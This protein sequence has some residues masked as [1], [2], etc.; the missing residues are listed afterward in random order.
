MSETNHTPLLEVRDV[1][2]TFVVRP[3]LGRSK[4]VHALKDISFTIEAGKA[5]ALVGESGSGKSTCGRAIARMF[6]IDDG[7]I[8]FKGKDVAAARN[9]AERRANA[10]HIQMVFQD[11]F[12]SLNPTHTIRHHLLR[13]LR[14]HKRVAAGQTEDEAL[15]QV[16][17]DVELDVDNTLDKYP[18]QLSGGQRQRVNLAR[19]L[20]VGAELIIADEPTSML[21]VS[22]RRSVLQLMKRLKEERGIA[23]LYITHD[24]ATA[25][26]LAEDTAA[27]FAGRIVEFGPSEEVV[28]APLHPYTK[29]L[30]SSVSDPHVKINPSI[31]DAKAF[32]DYADGVRA[33]TETSD[34]PIETIRPGRQVRPVAA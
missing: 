33:R 8:L 23:F 18:H 27:M 22:I 11:P 30:L 32:S 7:R 31:E 3:M 6:S 19:A 17:A 21:D 26:Y 15:R 9:P 24:L 2:K 1:K 34:A 16:L 28:R 14:L 25:R 10:R 13:P 29:L 12:A 5:L 4:E 20:A